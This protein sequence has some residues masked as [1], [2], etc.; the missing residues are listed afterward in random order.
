MWGVADG[1]DL[2]LGKRIPW[3]YIPGIKQTPFLIQ[4]Y[5]FTTPGS[6]HGLLLAVYSGVATGDER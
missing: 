6:A 5:Y 2:T 4:F 3:N 1:W